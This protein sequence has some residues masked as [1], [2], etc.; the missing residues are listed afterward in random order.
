MSPYLQS[1]YDPQKILSYMHFMINKTTR[2]FRQCCELFAIF[3]PHY[4]TRENEII[5]RL[6][7]LTQLKSNKQR[8]KENAAMMN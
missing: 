7:M 8:I 5:L 1:S 2:V 4:T 6:H 3:H